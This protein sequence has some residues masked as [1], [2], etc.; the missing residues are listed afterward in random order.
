LEARAATNIILRAAGDGVSPTPDIRMDQTMRNRFSATFVSM[1][2]LVMVAVS[3]TPAASSGFDWLQYSDRSSG[4]CM[5]AVHDPHIPASWVHEAT[6]MTP[7]GS[8]AAKQVFNMQAVGNG[9]VLIKEGESHYCL[10][11][12]SSLSDGSPIMLLC[13]NPPGGGSSA[14]EEWQVLFHSEN[15]NGS[16]NL[17]FRNAYSQKC[18][19]GISSGAMLYQQTCD[20]TNLHQVWHQH[21]REG[22]PTCIPVL[23]HRSS[24]PLCQALNVAA[25]SRAFEQPCALRSDGVEFASEQRSSATTPRAQHARDTLGGGTD[26]GIAELAIN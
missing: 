17:M 21:L 2:V 18:V 22:C 26:I 15:R 5:E 11:V 20:R 9:N 13:S 24:R 1:C 14:T 6:C 10:N 8:G 16:V 4:L 25:I 23:R 12:G 7:G 19:T 3:V